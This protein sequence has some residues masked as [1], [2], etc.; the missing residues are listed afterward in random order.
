MKA[1]SLAKVIA[2]DMLLT[3]EVR[4]IDNS[5]KYDVELDGRYL[6]TSPQPFFDAARLLLE[7]GYDPA[8][9]LQMRRAGRQQI[10]L[11]APLGKAAGLTVEANSLGRPIFRRHRAGSGKASPIRP[12]P[13]LVPDSP[14]ASET[15][16]VAHSRTNVTT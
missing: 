9:R 3:L 4:E 8:L 1:A 13:P 16:P 5:G 12:A 2:H 6:L 10:D 14:P 15:R 7:Q 11:A